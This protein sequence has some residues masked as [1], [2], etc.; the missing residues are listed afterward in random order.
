M[1]KEQMSPKGIRGKK[2]RYTGD[3]GVG[4]LA[5]F[6]MVFDNLGWR[7]CCDCQCV[8]F[9]FFLCMV[10]GSCSNCQGL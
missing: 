7:G 8:I 1:A 6:Q 10:V 4:Q 3:Y 5:R 9:F 2:N